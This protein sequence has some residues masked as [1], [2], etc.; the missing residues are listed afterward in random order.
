[1]KIGILLVLLF[2]LNLFSLIFVLV[3]FM[4][5]LKILNY[6]VFFKQVECAIGRMKFYK[7]LATTW[8]LNLVKCANSILLIIGAL[9]NLQPPLVK[10]V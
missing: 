9:V 8:D 6:T 3:P 4:L 10:K 1:M 7:I 5:A 2:S